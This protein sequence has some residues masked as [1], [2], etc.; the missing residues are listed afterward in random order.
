MFDVEMTLDRV[1]ELRMHKPTISNLRRSFLVLDWPLLI[2][3]A[4]LVDM[5]KLWWRWS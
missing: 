4:S 2:A 3:D 1:L 5:L